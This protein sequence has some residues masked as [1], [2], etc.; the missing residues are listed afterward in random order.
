MCSHNEACTYTHTQ[1]RTHMHKTFAALR[2]RHVARLF[3]ALHT[4]TQTYTLAFLC[5]LLI[6]YFTSLSN[7]VFVCCFFFAATF[8]QIF[9]SLCLRAFL[10]FCRFLFAALSLLLLLLLLQSEKK[11]NDKFSNAASAAA[12]A[13]TAKRATL[14][15]THTLV[16]NNKQAKST[17]KTKKTKQRQWGQKQL[18]P[19]YASGVGSLSMFVRS[20]SE[21]ALSRCVLIAMRQ[22]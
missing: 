5:L 7:F 1:T 19:L 3:A 9:I 21:R 17:E 6:T 12:A 14:T 4:H 15:H 8:A 13:A 16:S 22:L 11:K 10:L 2:I 18:L 20:L